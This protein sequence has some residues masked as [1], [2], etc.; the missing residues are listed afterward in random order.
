MPTPLHA[1]AA[2]APS[3]FTLHSPPPMRTLFL[4]SLPPAPGLAKV[5]RRVPF[6]LCRRRT[7]AP[8]RVV[9]RASQ[10]S[11][12]RHG[13]AAPSRSTTP[14]PPR[15]YSGRSQ[16]LLRAPG[17]GDL[18][19][20]GSTGRRAAALHARISDLSPPRSPAYSAAHPDPA[21]SSHAG[22]RAASQPLAADLRPLSA[23]V[24]RS[25]KCR[26]P[27]GRNRRRREETA[28]CPISAAPLPCRCCH[29]A[30]VPP[31]AP[32]ATI[33]LL[34]AYASPHPDVGSTC[35]SEPPKPKAPKPQPCS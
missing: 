5:R 28:P 8:P 2:A 25:R 23:T 12:D 10:P 3:A 9:R 16:A 29:I 7:A 20:C 21:T 31:C 4:P 17:S 14:S 32:P 26:P 30:V 22:Q 19:S 6:L 11:T 24:G 34:P 13:T 27:V 18:Q 35:G 1:A 15:P 33:C